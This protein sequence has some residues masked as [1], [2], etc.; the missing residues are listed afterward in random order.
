[1]KEQKQKV[2]L[3]KAIEASL[4]NGERILNDAEMLLYPESAPTAFALSVLAQEE[5]AKA[6]LLYLVETQCVLWDN[7]IVRALNDHS[8]K[9]LMCLLID[10]L[11]PDIDKFLERMPAIERKQPIL[12]V[13]IIDTINIIRHE[14]LDRSSRSDWIDPEDPHLEPIVKKIAD[15]DFDKLKQD[16]LYVRIGH[17][18]EVVSE[19]NKITLKLAETELEKAKRFSHVLYHDNGQI[20]GPIGLDYEKVSALLK[21]LFGLVSP[22]E[23]NKNWWL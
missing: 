23:F 12:P 7:N 10:F 3:N 9:Q 13:H 21:V 22:E 1:M 17:A 4:R 6:F 11:S 15:G 8:C 5:F 18:G 2:S 20:K 16:A 19:P 14:K